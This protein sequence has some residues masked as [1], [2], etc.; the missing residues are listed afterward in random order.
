MSKSFNRSTEPERYGFTTTRADNYTGRV[1]K[2]A[3]PSTNVI[4]I[5][6]KDIA[7]GETNVII[8]VRRDILNIADKYG[9]LELGPTLLINWLNESLNAPNEE[10]WLAAAFGVSNVK[11]SKNTLYQQI[12]RINNAL[13]GRD[14]R[15]DVESF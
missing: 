3:K 2:E 11:K 12:Q 13:E 1:A 6:E 8:L 15:V 5:H 7:T 4:V 10:S 14:I 9:S